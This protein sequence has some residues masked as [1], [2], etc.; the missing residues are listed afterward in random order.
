MSVLVDWLWE[1]GRK[2]WFFS[3]KKTKR[4]QA[5]ED[6]MPWNRQ[7]ILLADDTCAVCGADRPSSLALCPGPTPPNRPGPRPL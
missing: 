5:A 1:L 4:E 7:H 2:A 6:A 3:R